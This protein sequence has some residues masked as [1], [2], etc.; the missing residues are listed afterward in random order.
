MGMSI[1]TK[2]AL[3][4]VTALCLAAVLYALSP[5]I[6][7][8]AMSQFV[9]YLW[10]TLR[11]VPASVYLM[12][13]VAYC[14]FYLDTICHEMGHA[15]V[16]CAVGAPPT[17][18]LIGRR[19]FRTVWR[20]K[21]LTVKFGRGPGD[22]HVH[23]PIYPVS[24]RKRMAMVAGGVSASA[25]ALVVSWSVIPSVLVWLKIESAFIF[26]VSICGNLFLKPPEDAK[27]WPDGSNK[28]SDGQ[29]LVGLARIWIR[30]TRAG[31]LRQNSAK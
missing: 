2:L 5:L 27:K 23:C 9:V 26:V 30:R 15:I 17:N 3:V 16:A 18:I 21:A 20:S 7:K 1:R 31:R 14:A 4:T 25:L 19:S 11:A 12:V 10:M 22:G 29:A 8:A 6:G 13:P 28:W 24:V